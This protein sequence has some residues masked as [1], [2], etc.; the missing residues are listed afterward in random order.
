M[1]LDCY[2]IVSII[3]IRWNS[4]SQWQSQGL[5]INGHKVAL[6]FHKFISPGFQK[7]HVALKI[8]RETHS[9]LESFTGESILV[10]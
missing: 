6:K 7:F 5:S 1:M 10:W 4:A 9:V 8:G 2:Y 3:R